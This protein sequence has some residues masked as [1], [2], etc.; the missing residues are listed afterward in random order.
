MGRLARMTSVVSSGAVISS[1]PSQMKAAPCPNAIVR[2]RDGLAA[3]ALSGG[4]SWNVTPSRR[5]KVQ[6]RASSLTCQFVASTPS[7]GGVSLG[8]PGSSAA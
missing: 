4:P 6:V 3:A 1:T 5:V 2:S 8:S 7:I